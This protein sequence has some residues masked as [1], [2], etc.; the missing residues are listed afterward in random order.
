[1]VSL[2]DGKSGIEA[3]KSGSFDL[4][5][6]GPCSCLA[7][8]GLQTTRAIRQLNSVHAGYRSLRLHAGQVALNMPNFNAMAAEAGAFSTLYKPFQPAALF[9]AIEKA[10]HDVPPPVLARRQRR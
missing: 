3:V 6:D 4:V 9:Q 7:F 5:I 10:F 1:M 8:D 2:P